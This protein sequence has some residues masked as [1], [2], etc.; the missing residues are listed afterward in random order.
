MT[1]AE[2]LETARAM[3]PFPAE[4]AREYRRERETLVA[5]VNKRLLERPDAEQLVGPGNLAMMRDNHGNH[6]RFVES[7]LECYHPDVLVETVLWV[8]RA[9]RA[10]GFR[11]TYWPAQLNAWVEVLQLRLSPESFAAIY[12]LYRWFIIHIP[13][14]VAL[15]DAPD[16]VDPAAR[17]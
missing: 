12:P 3:P 16:T 10:H 2:L 7:L 11:L 6:A 14:F 4:A 5:D 1:R 9:Y 8:F 15:T 17:E 13:T